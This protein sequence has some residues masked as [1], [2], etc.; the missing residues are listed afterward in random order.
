[1]QNQAKKA[2]EEDLDRMLAELEA[3]S[4]DEARRIIAEESGKLSRGERRD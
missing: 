2:G 4:D 3:L 1:M